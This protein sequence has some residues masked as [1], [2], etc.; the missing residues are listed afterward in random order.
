MLNDVFN[1]LYLWTDKNNVYRQAMTGRENKR[2]SYPKYLL[3]GQKHLDIEKL[4]LIYSKY[5]A[6]MIMSLC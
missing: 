2:Y 6:C 1:I 4:T 3:Q 5:I